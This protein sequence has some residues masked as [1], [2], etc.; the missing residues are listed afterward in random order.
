MS[1]KP[2]FW[3]LKHL[4]YQKHTRE[5]GKKPG[6]ILRKISEYL[7]EHPPLRDL[8]APLPFACR[9]GRFYY[10]RI[11]RDGLFVVVF[12]HEGQEAWQKSVEEWVKELSSRQARWSGMAGR[13]IENF[14]ATLARFV[15][16]VE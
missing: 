4:D 14:H 2:A 9:E 8:T 15:F 13:A 12:D 6:V 5:K 16:P 7:R 1:E 3:W 10:L 11:T